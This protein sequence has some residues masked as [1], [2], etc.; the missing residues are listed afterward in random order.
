MVFGGYCF[1]FVILFLSIDGGALTFDLSKVPTTV[2]KLPSASAPLAITRRDAWVSSA[3]A[4]ATSTAISTIAA[5]IGQGNVASALEPKDSTSSRTFFVQGTVN[6]PAEFEK[7]PPPPTL[8]AD[9]GATASS[10]APAL[11]ITCRPDRPDNVP[12]A[13]LAGTRGKPPPVLAARFENPTSFPFFFVL[14][15]QDLT[16]EG[17]VKDETTGLYWWL[18]AANDNHGSSSNNKD[19]LVV[20]ARWDSDG[21]AAT[22]SPEDLVGRATA[23]QKLK[24]PEHGNDGDDSLSSSPIMYTVAIDLGGRGAFGKFATGGGGGG[25]TNK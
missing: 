15:E 23:K 4:I 8:A 19:N 14:G 20:S 6:R 17:S 7:N 18:I 1:I 11:Y 22:R 16:L 2:K 13:I 21:F 9:N 12:Q 5:N 10:T 25:G 24:P 3:F